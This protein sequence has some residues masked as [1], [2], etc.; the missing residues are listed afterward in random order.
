MIKGYWVPVK[1][2]WYYACGEF[3]AEGLD[4]FNT[5]QKYYP[6]E[7]LPATE[8]AYWDPSKYRNHNHFVFTICG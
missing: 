2:N 8:T 3:G 7:W 4:A 6:K 1:P 5:M